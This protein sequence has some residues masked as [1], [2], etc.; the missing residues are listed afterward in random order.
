MIN[1]Y[2]NSTYAEII[3]KLFSATLDYFGILDTLE[4]DFTFVSEEEIREIN[5]R[6]RGYDSVTDV[7]SFPNVEVSLPLN[8]EDYPLDINPETNKLL[9][10]EILICLPIIL[11]NA[12]EYGNSNNGEIAY[13]TVHGMLHLLG[14]DHIDEREKKIMRVLEEE[15]LNSIGLGKG[16]R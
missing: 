14:F 8:I 3:N 12:K 4:V 1:I 9:L 16:A 7:L 2:N 10:G 5:N 13:M 6:T 15:I 11:N